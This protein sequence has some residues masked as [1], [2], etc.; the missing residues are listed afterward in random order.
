MSGMR[1]GEALPCQDGQFGFR[2]V[3]PAAMLWGVMPLETVGDAPCFVGRESAIERG[4]G[5]GV[6]IV[7][8]QSDG[9][10]AREMD[11]TQLFEHMGVIDG[12]A[13]G[14]DTDMTPP[15]QRREQHEQ[16]GGA[17]AL[18]FVILARNRRA[19]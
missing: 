2:H 19:S 17:T 8:D 11:I 6:Q 3:E 9:L 16:S 10:G 5:V 15:F 13:M 7:L 1:A 4:R 18:V 14:G 12:R